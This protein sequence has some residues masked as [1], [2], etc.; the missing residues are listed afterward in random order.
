M[1]NPEGVRCSIP[2]YAIATWGAMPGTH[3]ARRTSD[4]VGIQYGLKALE[5]GQVTAEEFV[6]LNERIGGS[7]VDMKPTAARMVAD[8]QA[9]RIAYEVGIIGAARQWAK[10]PMI[11]L[12]GN[13]NSGIHMN[14]RAFAVRDRLDRVNGGHGNQ[15][16]WRYGPSLLPPPQL[17]VDSLV[18]MDKWVAAIQADRSA[19]PL[20]QKV[21]KNR[22]AEAFDFCYIGT[23]YAT[24]MTDQKACDADPVLKYFASPRQT[25]GGPL[26]ED[27]LKC[28]LKPLKR[29]DYKTALSDTQW[30]RLNKVFSGGVCDWTK[31]G[32]GMQRSVPWQTFAAGPGG[33]PMPAPPRSK[34]I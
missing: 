27:V 17:L 1:K 24:K 21:V 7:D 23:D 26:A 20:E 34:R 10:V 11:D 25:A 12:R 19:E 22:P 8:E 33:E 32:I 13:D 14:W 28:R 5:A 9:L 15:V 2:E 4:N 29:S 3:V 31:P 30:T 6:V 18:M 16:I